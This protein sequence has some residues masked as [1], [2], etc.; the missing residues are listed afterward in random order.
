MKLYHDSQ[1]SQCRF[2][3]GAVPCM[4]LVTF[5]LRCG[6][7][8]RS[9]MLRF[10]DGSEKWVPMKK[11]KGGWFSA[12]ARMPQIPILCWYDFRAEDEDGVI[13]GY[14]APADGLGGEGVAAEQPRAWQL[15]VYDP[16]FSTPDWMH[17]GVMYQIFPDRFY[18]EGDFR[19]RREECFYHE[20]WNEDPIL[21]P[22]GGDDNCARDFFGGNLEG[23]REKLPYLKDLGV[24]VLYL[25]PIFQARSNHRYDTADYETIDPLL[26]TNQDFVRLCEDAKAQ[27]IR[28]MLDGVF[29][30][31]GEDSLYFNRYG[32]Y[33]TVGAC[34]STHSPYY[35]W[36][37]FSRYPD[38]YASWWGFHTLPEI[39]KDN[40]SYRYFMFN[41]EN[42]VTRQWLRRGAAGWRLDVADELPMSFIRQLRAAV[43]AQDPDAVVLGEVWEDASHKVAYG[44]MRCYCQG[45]TLDSVM[46]YPL[47]EAARDFFLGTAD[48]HALRRL[49]LSQQENYAPPFYYALMNLAGS[50]DRPRAINMLCQH[51]WEELPNRERGHQRLTKKQYELGAQRYVKM[52]QLLCALP[53]IPC[54]YYGDEV[55]MQGSA[56]PFC[57]CPFPWDHQDEAL[58]EQIKA[59]LWQRRSSRALQTG[60][61]QVEAVNRDTLR[62]T[63]SITGGRDALGQP[64]PDETVTIEIRR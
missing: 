34:Q 15:T 24:T 61:L 13:Y 46:N 43:K 19:Q 20:N 10:Y 18:K 33:P 1:S 16:D 7:H 8:A 6:A 31:T 41:P 14:G 42:G 40:E 63:R 45:D 50:H 25:N 38:Q 2:P 53:G 22:E 56:D 21:M 32:R 54:V 26:G 12:Q 52:V 47:L 59:L 28:I 37:K 39:D 57:R 36:Y 48:A 49:I 4:T 27:G 35:P 23:I 5:R 9:A 58:K 11:E 55:G 60:A 17:T 30:H 44:E 64:A 51:T 62:I 29:S 3:T